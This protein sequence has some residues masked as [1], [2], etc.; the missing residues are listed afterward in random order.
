MLKKFDTTIK[1]ERI[2]VL[3]QLA[4]RAGISG[5]VNTYEETILDLKT[6]KEYGLDMQERATYSAKVSLYE[7]EQK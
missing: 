2:K 7:V 1:S 6:F 5:Q 3:K 4:K